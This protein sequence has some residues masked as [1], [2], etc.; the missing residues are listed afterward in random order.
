MIESATWSSS[1][2]AAW[3]T[4]DRGRSPAVADAR[5]RRALLRLAARHG[6]VRVRLKDGAA[7]NPGAPE[8]L[9][10]LDALNEGGLLHY[11]GLRQDGQGAELVYLHPN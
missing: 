11:G 1:G 8:V 5:R 6:E 7:V 2:S 4:E 3:R 9:E 10:L